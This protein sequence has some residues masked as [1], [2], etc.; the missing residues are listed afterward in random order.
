MKSEGKLGAKPLKFQEE[1]E[2]TTISGT[3]LALLV[4]SKTKM[5]MK[6]KNYHVEQHTKSPT[7]I[8]SFYS[9]QLTSY[10]DSFNQPENTQVCIMAEN[11]S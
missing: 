5:K 7:N 1:K 11:L 3:P 4:K 10:S 6:K 2:T 8:S 9:T